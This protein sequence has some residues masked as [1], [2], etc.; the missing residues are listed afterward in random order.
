[1]ASDEVFISAQAVEKISDT[2]INS[3]QIKILQEENGKVSFHPPNDQKWSIVL[4][5]ETFSEGT[6]R[7][8]HFGEDDGE[9]NATASAD[10]LN[11]DA[12]AK[13]IQI[14]HDTY[15]ET[16]KEFFG[17]TVIAM[18]TDE[19]DLLGRGSKRGL[20]AWTSH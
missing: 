1:M 10:L 11:P 20:K 2:E 7:G 9:E 14:T 16:L 8:I 12:V 17:N 15:Y 6:I 4:F 5:I 19:P 3:E 18:F 13:F